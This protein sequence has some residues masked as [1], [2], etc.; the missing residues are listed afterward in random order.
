[1]SILEFGTTYLWPLFAKP[2]AWQILEASIVIVMWSIA[3]KLTL[4]M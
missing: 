2:M 1:V 4:G 3:L